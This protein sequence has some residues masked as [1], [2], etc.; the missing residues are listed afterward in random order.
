[1]WK[2]SPCLRKVC[3]PRPQNG[4][5]SVCLVRDCQPVALL[6]AADMGDYSDETLPEGYLEQ[7]GLLGPQ[8]RVGEEGRLRSS[9]GTKGLKKGKR[10]HVLLCVSMRTCYVHTCVRF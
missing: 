2:H 6:S 9:E 4:C 5:Q 8:V 10:W 7:S 3:Q 1:M